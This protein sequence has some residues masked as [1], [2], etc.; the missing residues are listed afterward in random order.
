ME[1]SNLGNG[2]VFILYSFDVQ[3][4][5]REEGQKLDPFAL[6]RLIMH[7][8]SRRKLCRRRRKKE[9]EFSISGVGPSTVLSKQ[10][11]IHNV[12]CNEKFRL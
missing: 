12:I 6:I 1:G 11:L 3:A 8:Y 7:M 10:I 4:K 9:F 5:R 2:K